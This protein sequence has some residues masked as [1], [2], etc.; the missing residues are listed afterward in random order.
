MR[1]LR[2]NQEDR[3]FRIV[4]AFA[5]VTCPAKTVDTGAGLG[6]KQSQK[7]NEEQEVNRYEPVFA[8]MRRAAILFLGACSLSGASV[9]MT[10]NTPPD[11]DGHPAVVALLRSYDGYWTRPFCSGMLLSS[12]VVLTASHCLAA[13]Q[14]Y[15]ANG[16]QLSVTNDSTLARDANGWLAIGSLTTN[17]AVGE[18]ALNPAYNPKILGGYD[19]DVSALVIANPIELAPDKFPTLPPAGLLDQLQADGTLRAATFTVLGYGSEQKALPANTGPWF[20]F[21]SERRAGTLGFDALDPRFIHESQRV[22]QNSNGACYGDSGG[23]SLL[24]V[25]GITYVVAVT[26]SGDIPCF[27]TNTAYRTDTDEALDLLEEVLEENP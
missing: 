5:I 3:P 8:P 24:Q 6:L 14:W 23:P 26:S 11:G 12:K 2:G 10:T 9:A 22:S 7:D 27:A 18:I 13:A 21:T 25:G 19:H 20:P 1:E 16:W 4:A 17:S 15:H